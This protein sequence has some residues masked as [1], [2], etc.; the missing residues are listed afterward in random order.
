MLT[1][2][3]CLS[4][5]QFLQQAQDAANGSGASS[6]TQAPTST[7]YAAE[8]FGFLGSIYQNLENSAKDGW[9]SVTWDNVQYAGGLI[10][11]FGW[12]FYSGYSFQDAGGLIACSGRGFHSG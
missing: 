3:I 12:G 1:E 8:D 2:T 6:S 5:G 9:D 11:C 7:N 10:A 4:T